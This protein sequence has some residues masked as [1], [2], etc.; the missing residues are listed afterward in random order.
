MEPIVYAADQYL[1]AVDGLLL[2]AGCSVL[3]SAFQRVCSSALGMT[4]C[5]EVWL[6]LA[7]CIFGANLQLL[8]LGVA[9]GG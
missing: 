4:P 3:C 8:A 6:H 5:L 2:G 1:L 9:H 7:L